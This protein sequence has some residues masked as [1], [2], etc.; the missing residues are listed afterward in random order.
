MPFGTKQLRFCISPERVTID[1]FAELMHRFGFF[2]AV[3]SK[4]QVRLFFRLSRYASLR[5]LASQLVGRF[6]VFRN[7]PLNYT[8]LLII[9]W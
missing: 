8:T 1:F 2:I 9:S 5:P 4:G 3:T 6:C 7:C